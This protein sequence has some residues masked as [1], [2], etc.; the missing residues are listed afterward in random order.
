MTRLEDKF[1]FDVIIGNPPYQSEGV[2]NVARDEPIYHLF[3]EEAYTISPKVMFITPAR[4]LFNAGQTPKKW[5]EKM[6]SDNHL[7][8]E[9]YEQK[10]SVIFPNTDIK[11]G[12]AITYR[13]TEQK[14]GKIGTFTAFS[15]LNGILHKVTNRDYFV[16]I[17]TILYGKS[18][19]K[20][21][22]DLYKDF[23]LLE[24]RISKSE[25]KSITSNIFEKMSEVFSDTQTD[26]NQIRI[27]GRENNIRVYK[28]IDRKY[29]E[30]HPNL[31]KYK[32][33]LPASN[34]SGAIGEVLST[35][36]VGT[37]LVGYTQTFISF[38]AFDNFDESNNLLKYVKSKFFRSLLGTMKVTQHN[39]SKE[40]W[41]NVPIQ[42]FTDSSDIDWSKSISEIDQQLYRKYG[43]SEE[44]I[45]FI[46]EK[47]RSMEDED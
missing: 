47:V 25:R 18:S 46:E 38:G 33:I 20:F 11:G 24:E 40:V 29:I 16:S 8:V 32:V 21:N 17:N 15:E 2:G 28:W 37:P 23:P 5:N 30:D 42:D 1:Q 31:D 27:L 35:P 9:Y 3:M 22:L 26:S 39:Q 41:K 7:R 19:Y 6:L 4:F 10:S 43:L 34:G 12:I 45:Q 44:E 36:L 14:F 13:D